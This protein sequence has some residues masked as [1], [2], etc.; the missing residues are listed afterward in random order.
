MSRVENDSEMQSVVSVA[1][2][3]N[4]PSSFKIKAVLHVAPDMTSALVRMES[5]SRPVNT[6]MRVALLSLRE[7]DLEALT[8]KQRR[9][10]DKYRAKPRTLSTEACLCQ[11]LNI[12]HF[13][14]A[15][16]KRK[17]TVNVFG[18]F[19]VLSDSY[20]Y[21][22]QLETR[23]HVPGY[24]SQYVDG[25]AI[26]SIRRIYGIYRL[27]VQ[28]KLMIYYASNMQKDRK[29][30]TLMRTKFL[31]AG[32]APDYDN[33]TE[34]DAVRFARL[35]ENRANA[36]SK[37][38]L[39]RVLLQIADKVTCRLAPWIPYSTLMMYSVPE[40]QRIVRALE[41]DI[42]NAFDFDALRIH[43][44]ALFVA[45]FGHPPDDDFGVAYSF[46][47]GLRNHLYGSLTNVPNRYISTITVQSHPF[48]GNGTVGM[49]AADGGTIEMHAA[50]RDIFRYREIM[51]RCASAEIIIGD[52][53]N[54]DEDVYCLVSH[55][56]DAEV[57]RSTS[58]CDEVHL[59]SQFAQL[60]G[61]ASPPMKIAIFRAHMWGLEE[62]VLFTESL[63][64]ECK[65][66]IAGRLDQHAIGRGQIFRDLTEE[67][68]AREKHCTITNDIECAVCIPPTV[69][70]VFYGGYKPVAIQFDAPERC[71]NKIWL[72][73]P[74]RI[75]TIKR[76]NDRGYT[77][78]EE[79]EPA[80]N[81]PDLSRFE[82]AWS[83]HVRRYRGPVV[84][85]ALMVV[86][87]ATPFDLYT[88]RTLAR[89]VTYVQS[90]LQ[91]TPSLPSSNGKLP[92]RRSLRA[93]L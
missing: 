6:H 12:P 13:P 60:H 83:C 92:R 67:C 54:C 52:V 77:Q 85:H 17:V 14:H 88:V 57:W 25:H 41:Q 50:T 43:H 51:R 74:P 59:L 28:P 48:I 58:D 84:S 27:N 86:D 23:K 22:L 7:S 31:K 15:Q 87:E 61:A 44:P 33:L 82:K 38:F 46:R 16:R 34:R 5:V 29:V 11:Y 53:V 75:R 30:K 10:Y 47:K 62:W 2:P 37:L 18:S 66:K 69:T 1:S 89:K 32:F 20:E 81:M 70:Q 9:L 49:G 35:R 64:P 65:L 45:S 42:S 91:Q 4:A 80:M 39:E 90:N 8:P 72:G 76:R 21:E 73:R 3:E 63:H 71:K 93:T 19:P 68:G 56:D 55:P 36:H 24:I 40:R 78:F 26:F 79:S